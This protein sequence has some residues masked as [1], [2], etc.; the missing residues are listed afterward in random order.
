MGF[1]VA[2][3]VCLVPQVVNSGFFVVVEGFVGA[4]VGNWPGNPQQKLLIFMLFALCYVIVNFILYNIYS[5]TV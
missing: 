5:F 3:V 4:L 1:C 2:L